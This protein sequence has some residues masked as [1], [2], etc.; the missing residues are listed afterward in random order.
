MGDTQVE[1]L[2]ESQPLVQGSGGL[3]SVMR[4]SESC[5]TSPCTMYCH[6][7][8]TDLTVIIGY[9]GKDTFYILIVKCIRLSLYK[10]CEFFILQ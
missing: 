6:D 8:G 2:V 3:H 5:Q 4:G 10:R 7:G 9:S 1:P